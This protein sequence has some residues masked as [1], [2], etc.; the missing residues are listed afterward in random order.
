MT[1]MPFK[2][3]VDQGEIYHF[4]VKTVGN[5]VGIDSY[6]HEIQSCETRSGFRLKLINSFITF[7]VLRRR[8]TSHS[9][10]GHLIWKSASTEWQQ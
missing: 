4:V 3:A 6:A 10:A 9:E 2:S 1:E 8:S 5:I 7:S